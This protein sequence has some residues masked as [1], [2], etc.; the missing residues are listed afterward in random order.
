MNALRLPVALAFSFLTMTQSIRAKNSAP[1]M[2][3]ARLGS[4]V[5]N[6]NGFVTKPSGVGERRDVTDG[7]TA[8]LE[9]FE[10][11]ISTLDP[12]RE[13]HP[14]H[15]H[16]QEEF[17]I[18]KEGMLDVYI[19]GRTQRVGPGT[20][21]FCAAHDMHNVR[22][23]GNTPATYLVFNVT[24]AATH[25]VPEKPAAESAAPDKLRSS[26]FEW[27]KLEA[28]PTKV[29][30]RR[31]ILE[32]PTVTCAKLEAHATTLNAGEVPHPAHHHP[33]EEIVV[34]KEGS[35]QATL[36]GIAQPA[37]G[38]GSIFYFASNEEH[39]LKNVG[40]TMATYYV[41]RFVTEKT[42]PAELETM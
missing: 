32:S 19:N 8:T 30:A 33:Q 9:R 41:I 31:Q 37:A 18:L 6:W 17:I 14:P 11:H 25:S 39:G 5:F 24:T 34:V 29:G 2:T 3:Q 40:G 21:F 1:V 35:V 12:G 26:I 10:C 20:L 23:A 16:P 4:T 15:H 28:K 13:S 22:N 38:P 42:P 7:P 36:N 27:D